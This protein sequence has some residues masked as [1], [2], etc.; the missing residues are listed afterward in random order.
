[1]LDIFESFIGDLSGADPNVI[2]VSACVLAIF[3]FDC[4]FRI[5]SMAFKAMFGLK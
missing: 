2:I 5:I 3:V 4:V 1:M